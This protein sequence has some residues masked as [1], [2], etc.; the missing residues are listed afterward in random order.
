MIYSPV[1]VLQVS[2]EPEEIHWILFSETEKERGENHLAFT[3]VW[4]SECILRVFPIYGEKYLDDYPCW[5]EDLVLFPLHE[6]KVFQSEC[7]NDK[8]LQKY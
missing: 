8:S 4:T 5:A 1:S 6:V 2:G 7:H 3:M